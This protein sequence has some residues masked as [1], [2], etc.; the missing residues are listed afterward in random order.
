MPDGD[1]VSVCKHECM[2]AGSYMCS[3]MDV[4]EHFIGGRETHTHT[5][6]HTGVDRW[7]W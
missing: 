3:H 2:L 7:L 5:Q 6:T 4:S 1:C